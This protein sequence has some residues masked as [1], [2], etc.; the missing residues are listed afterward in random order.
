MIIYTAYLLYRLGGA[1]LD[2]RKL[3]DLGIDGLIHEIDSQ[4]LNSF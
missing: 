4:P 2:F 3:F 1:Y